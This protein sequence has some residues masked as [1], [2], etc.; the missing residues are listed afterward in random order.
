MTSVRY[1]HI[2]CSCR[3]FIRCETTNISV[4]LLVGLRVVSGTNSAAVNI[5]ARALRWMYDR[6]SVGCALWEVALL[7]H[8]IWATFS[9]H[10]LRRLIIALWKSQMPSSMPTLLFGS[11]SIWHIL[12]THPT[13]LTEAEGLCFFCTCLPIT[14]PSAENHQDRPQSVWKV[15]NKSQSQPN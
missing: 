3:L 13:E 14:S 5:L 9:F 6:L 7:G 12:F 8:R 1:P 11:H 2:V 4:T 10:S 15:V